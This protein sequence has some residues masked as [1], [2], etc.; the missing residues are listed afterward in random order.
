MKGMIL[1]AGF[2]TRLR[3]V[4]YQMPKP[5]AP[6]C[7]RPLIGYAV[8]A[9]IRAGISEV[10]VNLHHLPDVLRNWLP[11]EYEGRVAFEFSYEPEI[12]GTGGGIR[13]VRHLLES[14]DD[15]ALMNGDTIQLPPLGRLAEVRRESDALAALLLR[16][17]PANDR[18]TKV[19]LEDGFITGFREGRG[20]ALMFAGC[21]VISRRVFDLLPDRPFSGI[22][23]DVYMPAT[24]RSARELAA[25]VDDGTWFDIGT[26]QRFL[27]ASSDVLQLMVRGRLE[28]PADSTVTAGSLIDHSA[29]VEGALDSSTVWR[30]SEIASETMITASS[31]WERVTIGRGTRIS[32][33]I[34]ASGVELP[35]GSR[36]ENA[37][38]CRR[39][40]GVDYPPEVTTLGDFAFA[41]VHPDAA[42]IVEL[43]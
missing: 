31:I 19:F 9:M 34:I 12:L 14:A 26:P 11:R 35:A 8:E 40:E 43:G 21:H 20:E 39:L 23:E 38:L 29:R 27:T 36:V 15:F 18:F 16:H 17:P 25:V 2:G 6:L 30:E 5:M 1:A 32:S 7:N 28:A 4:T 24:A 42:T 41:P 13:N 3:P 22:T 37:L 10:V 33:S